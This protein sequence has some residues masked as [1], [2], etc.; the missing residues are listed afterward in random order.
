[1]YKIE[2]MASPIYKNNNLKLLG[3]G[4]QEYMLPYI[5]VY[6]SDPT[7][8]INDDVIINLYSC[9]YKQPD[10]YCT[11]PVD[12]KL[13]VNIDETIKTYDIKS[14]DYSINIGTQPIG[15]HYYT[16][17][18][19]DSQGRKSNQLYNEFR[20]INKTEY[21]Q[22]IANNTYT[23]T[24]D[25]LLEYNISKNDDEAVALETRDG[26]QRLIND[27]ASLGVRKMILPTGTYQ[28][29]TEVTYAGGWTPEDH[30]EDEL[31]TQIQYNKNILNIPSNFILDLNGSTIKEKTTPW[32]QN[33]AYLLSIDGAYDS[34]VING[35]LEGDYRRRSNQMRPDGLHSKEFGGCCI[36]SGASRY[37]SFEDITATK[38]QG[39]A[40]TF[41]IAAGIGQSPHSLSSNTLKSWT[42][43]D[44]NEFGEEVS[45]K[46]KW[47]S[48]F[49]EVQ[50]S[51]ID[52][53]IVRIGQYLGY[54]HYIQAD[55]WNTKYHFYDDNKNYISSYDGYMYREFIKPD[56]TKYFRA[57]YYIKPGS[58]DNI[59]DYLQNLQHM[60]IYYYIPRNCS[61]K[62]IDF[63]DTKTCAFN[64]NQANN[65]LIEECTFTECGTNITP[66]CIDFEDGWYLMQDYCVKN[67]NVLVPVGT[68]DI[69]IDA[70]MNLQYIGNKNCRYTVQG[71]FGIGYCFKDNINL[72][73]LVIKY[74][75]LNW[76]Y[77]R[78]I[79]CYFK[80]DSYFTVTNYDRFN[81]H[82]KN[83]SF[84]ESSPGANKTCFHNI[85]IDMNNKI[86]SVSYG[87]IVL[88]SGI[89]IDSKIEKFSGHKVDNTRIPD[90]EYRR[91][92]I[93]DF[94]GVLA[95]KNAKMIDCVLNDLT[96]YKS[97][98]D[99]VKLVLK[100]C[101]ITN[102]LFSNNAAVFNNRKVELIIEDCIIDNSNNNKLCII[103][104]NF[105]YLKD[106][107]KNIFVIKNCTLLNGTYIADDDMLSNDMI[108]WELENNI[109]R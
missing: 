96:I 48:D 51:L 1:M 84:F 22:E 38:F 67:C 92:T 83:L 60:M 37:C 89:F 75:N 13:Y 32:Y 109:S 100:K 70:G 39:Y 106:Q 50:S 55:S 40:C 71:G 94:K 14:G 66:A 41:G 46:N 76:N 90:C 21:D 99:G 88:P 20:V 103:D 93:T 2:K 63:V 79:N 65:C 6:Y 31:S 104:N 29:I 15:D 19:E 82:I 58:K 81:C 49:C 44:I 47:T 54:G 17:Q 101:T 80:S 62:R 56:N 108:L 98:I 91:S 30:T 59:P 85:N 33:K 8:D 53:K 86:P 74:G 27:K 73:A 12:F 9:E 69:I 25:D 107:Y 3:C 18:V 97:S 68:S 4:E 10:P 5:S 7:Y 64:P 36:I 72:R 77:N 78:I 26:L 87:V 61:F 52:K 57:T 42:N 34:H 28:I 35:T 102:F 16:V 11:N 105:R 24:D 45:D 43:V 95:G 23:V